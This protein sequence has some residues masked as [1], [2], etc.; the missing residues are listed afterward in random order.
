MPKSSLD[1]KT[2]PRM[3]RAYK[4]A[5]RY[6]FLE[7]III[8]THC[9]YADGFP[10]SPEER[11]LTLIRCILRSELW[12]IR[13]DLLQQQ[14]YRKAF[15]AAHNLPTG[16]LVNFI[17]LTVLPLAGE[18]AMKTW[19]LDEAKRNVGSAYD[20]RFDNEVQKLQEEQEHGPIVAVKIPHSGHVLYVLMILE[21][22][23]VLGDYGIRGRINRQSLL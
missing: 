17:D 16:Y 9:A 8:C 5:W 18:P 4:E 11:D 14:T 20:L 1:S 3:S 15:D 2:S 13:F 21:K 23:H 7:Y 19:T 22:T 6:C 10:R 12:S